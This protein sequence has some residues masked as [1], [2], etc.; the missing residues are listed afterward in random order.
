VASALAALCFNVVK[1]KYLKILC[2]NVVKT[3]YLKILAT[4]V[5]S[6][7]AH[8]CPVPQSGPQGGPLFLLPE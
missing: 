6:A 2:F 4:F 8:S 3:K 7:W 1:T 5:A